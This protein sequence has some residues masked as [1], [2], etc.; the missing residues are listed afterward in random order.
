MAEKLILPMDKL[1]AT[2]KGFTLIE[3]LLVLAIVSVLLV[4]TSLPLQTKRTTHTLF[5]YQLSCIIEEARLEA[6]DS[7]SHTSIEF[8]KNEICF[9][10]QCLE[11]I[12]VKNPQTVTFNANGHIQKGRHIDI[13]LN[14]ETF[15]LIFNVGEGAYHIE[16]NSFGFYFTGCLICFSDLFKRY[17][18][19]L[20]K[21][22]H[23]F[24]S[25][26]QHRLQSNCKVARKRAF[27]LLESL[28]ALLVSMVIIS[29]FSIFLRG[30]NHLKAPDNT[31]DIISMIVLLTEDVN[32]AN[33][34]IVNEDELVLEYASKTFTYSLNQGRLVKTPGFDIYLH[35]LDELSF[36]EDGKYLY[37]YLKRGDNDGWFYIGTSYR[38]QKG[39]CQPTG[40]DVD[41]DIDDG[42]IRTDGNDTDEIST[43]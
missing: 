6:I 32:T 4:V 42:S 33:Q 13:C 17:L 20:F 26:T 18:H 23:A 40:T 29:S 22:H 21:Y 28:F 39:V 35:Q 1:I 7:K 15:S 14:N 2:K 43:E 24:Q 5:W 31:D 19:S 37:I 3:M 34:V 10:N 16:K 38:P 9:E 41:D 36:S 11:D 25:I 8:L 30:L 12:V 27:T